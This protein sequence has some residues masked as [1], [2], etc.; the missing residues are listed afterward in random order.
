MTDVNIV[1]LI[2]LTIVAIGY[3]LKRMN[4][5]SEENGEVIA[6]IVFNLTLPAVI[7]KV[8]STIRFEISLL[9]LPLISLSYG[10]FMV[11]I[12][13]ILFK[14]Y[15]RNLK[16]LL[17]MSIIGFNVANFSFPLIEGIWGDSGLQLIAMVDAG[18]AVSIFIICFTIGKIYSPKNEKIEIIINFKNVLLSLLKSVPLICYIVAIIINF[19]GFSIPFFFSELIDIISRANSP[20][21]LLLLGVFL[22]FK[23]QKDQWLMIGKSLL[24]RYSIGLCCGL[25]LF[26]LLP[27]NIFSELFRIII[28]ISLIL[29]VGLAVIPFSVELEYDKKL[30][31]II[32]NFSI[33][34]SF[35]LMWILIILFSG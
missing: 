5:L 6:K 33:L 21:A 26:F 2:S 10:L 3:F 19:S 8:T 29:P 12:G 35:G 4:V 30:I 16:G 9:F 34:I 32:A 11:L 20:L 18:N 31:T 25:L 1:F 14:K 7:L 13:F 22:N 24:I 15:Q 23:F 17:F 27:A 28:T